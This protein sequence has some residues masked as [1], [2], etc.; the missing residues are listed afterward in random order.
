VC[1]HLRIE[2]ALHALSRDALQLQFV[3]AVALMPISLYNI[4]INRTCKS[5][6]TPTHAHDK[7]CSTP[8]SRISLWC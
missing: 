2:H 6:A 3:A 8:T 5:A 4:I 1:A 7:P